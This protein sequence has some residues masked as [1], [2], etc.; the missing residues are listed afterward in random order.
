LEIASKR[1][2][3]RGRERSR[4]IVSLAHTSSTQ[5]KSKRFYY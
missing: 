4:V 3:E 2:R 5:K 1:E